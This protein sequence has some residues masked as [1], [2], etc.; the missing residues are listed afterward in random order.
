MGKGKDGGNDVET[1]KEEI[2]DSR[3]EERGGG[4]GAEGSDVERCDRIERR[5]EGAEQGWRKEWRMQAD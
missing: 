5:R 3:D 1:R 2:K 4:E